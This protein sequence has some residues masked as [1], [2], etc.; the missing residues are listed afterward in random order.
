LYFAVILKADIADS[1]RL[2]QQDEQ[3]AHEYILEAFRR[4]SEN[5]GRYHGRLQEL[6]SDVLLIKLEL[7]SDVVMTTLSFKSD[8]QEH[9]VKYLEMLFNQRLRAG[10][11]L[12]TVVIADS[13]ITGAGVVL[14]QRVEQPSE[15]GEFCIASAIHGALPSHVPLRS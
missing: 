13:S 4:F 14:A 11:T 6:R 8:H 12:G 3:L 15:F 7:A 9:L 2:L 5:I 10:I 1:T